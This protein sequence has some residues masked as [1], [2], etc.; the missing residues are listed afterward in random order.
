MCGKCKVNLKG[1]PGG[2]EVEL[3]GLHG[4]SPGRKA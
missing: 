4:K 1:Q 2:L 3:V